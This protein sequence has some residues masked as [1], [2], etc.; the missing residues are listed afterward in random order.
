M[1]NPEEASQ[2][3]VGLNDCR[4]AFYVTTAILLGLFL[5]VSLHGS[6]V[7]LAFGH[8]AIGFLDGAWKVRNGIFPHADYSSALGALNSWILAVGF[9]SLGPTAAVLPFCNAAV[10]LALGFIAWLVAR[11]RLPAWLASGFAVTQ[12][13]VAI[14]PHLLRAHWYTTTYASY[15]NR[16]SYAVI[17]ILLLALSVPLS[18]G[19]DTRWTGRTVGALLGVLLFLKISFFVVGVGLSVTVAIF[20]RRWSRPFGWNLLAGF[21]AVFLACLPMIRFD[22]LAML[23]DMQMASGARAGVPGT[24]LTPWHFLSEMPSIWV[25]VALLAAMQLALRPP[26]LFRRG[27]LMALEPSWAELG[28]LAGAG[29]FIC[30]T[31]APADFQPENPLL[32]SW[33]FV[34]LAGALRR[35]APDDLSRSRPVLCGLGALLWVFTFHAGLVNLVWSTMPWLNP[36][37]K[38]HLAAS[39]VFDAEPLADLRI[40]G[41]GGEGGLRGIGENIPYADKV[42]DG[43]H[44]LRELSGPHRVAAFDF[45]N[46]FPFALQWPALRGGLWCWHLGYSFCATACPTADQAFGDAD[47]LMVPK[48]AGEPKSLRVM[49]EIYGGYILEHFEVA[50]ESREWILM[51]RF[52]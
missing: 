35:S 25:E 33:I 45:V 16:Q 2:A 23:R 49:R 12:M 21:L 37:Q 40:Y 47:V 26:W 46:P 39:P 17:S 43:L 15:Y 18:N 31:N 50:A 7:Q 38:F 30:V 8:D 34:L 42:N 22:V 41:D 51:R 32:T 9:W 1:L 29:L 52:R 3:G 13:I 4:R 6:C 11:D 10:A 44:L 20:A 24:G 48:H 19:G 5:L 27:G 36:T 14:A 28:A